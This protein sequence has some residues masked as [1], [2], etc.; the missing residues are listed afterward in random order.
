MSCIPKLLEKIV[1]DSLTH[2]VSCI[3][4]PCQ[5]GFRK[6]RSTTTNILELTTT[7][8]EGFVN[9]MQT[10]TIYTDFSKAFDK[11]NHELLLLKLSSMG[12]TSSLLNWLKSYLTNRTQ[13][14]KFRQAISRDILVSSGVPQGSHLGPVLFTLFINDLPSVINNSMVLMY[15]DDVKLSLTF[16][17]LED[18]YLLQRDIDN[19]SLWCNKNLMNLNI[20]KCKHMS[21]YRSTKFNTTYYVDE[22]LLDAVDTFLDLGIL[23]DSRLNF[24]SHISLTVNKATGVLGFMK[25]WCKEFADPYVTKQLYTSLVRPILEYGSVI[26]DPYYTILMG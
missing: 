21:F 3:L 5:H 2:Q 14:V 26:W 17:H 24:R 6:S 20:K 9:G 8:I 10:D 19:F 18:Q 4:S 12:F 23:L 1:T 15:A 22:I 11:V 16:N 7:V 25:R 13:Q